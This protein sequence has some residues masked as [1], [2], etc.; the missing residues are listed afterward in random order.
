LRHY[1]P[2]ILNNNHWHDVASFIKL[3]LGQPQEAAHLVSLLRGENQN[4]WQWTAN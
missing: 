1:W 4:E 3:C 2:N